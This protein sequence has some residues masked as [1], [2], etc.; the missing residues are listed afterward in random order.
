MKPDPK[1][2][3]LIQSDYGHFKGYSLPYSKVEYLTVRL[4]F[5]QSCI[6]RR[7]QTR[8]VGEWLLYGGIILGIVAGI[9]LGS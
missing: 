4:P 9:V 8:K 3:W 2:Y 7:E 6:D 5:C 1:T